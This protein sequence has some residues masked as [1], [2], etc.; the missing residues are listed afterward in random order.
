MAT[1]T[2]FQQFVEDIA[3]GAHNLN[4]DTLGIALTTQAFIPVVTNE[5][6]GNLTQIAYTNLSARTIT[7][8]SAVHT[9]G[10]LKL[11]LP[12]LLLTA[13]GAVATFRHV[14]LYNVTQTT[15]PVNPL[16]G[17]YDYGSDVTL[18]DTETFNIDFDQAAGVLT[19]V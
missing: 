11:L 4:T 8:T 9:T 16:I 3:V 10:T 1:F 7:P 15:A 5:I 17:W 19:I 18:A 14:V 12:D 2:K 6:L 13:S